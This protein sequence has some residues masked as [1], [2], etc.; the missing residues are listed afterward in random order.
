MRLV[1]LLCY[2][3]KKKYALLF[4]FT[5]HLPS[6]Q[7]ETGNLVPRREPWERGCETASFAASQVSQAIELYVNLCVKFSKCKVRRP[8]LI[9]DIDL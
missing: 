1:Y 9:R 8:P 5:A 2:L 7:T 6:R 4:L 3:K